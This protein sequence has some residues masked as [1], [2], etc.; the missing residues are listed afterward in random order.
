MY[1]NWIKIKYFSFIIAQVHSYDNNRLYEL[2]IVVTDWHFCHNKHSLNLVKMLFIIEF[3]INNIK[4]EFTHCYL[5]L[6]SES[7]LLHIR[8]VFL[9]HHK[10]YNEK[11]NDDQIDLP[12][13]ISFSLTS[14]FRLRND[15][16]IIIIMEQMKRRR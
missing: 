16:P 1:K 9:V 15:G 5:L 2:R 7:I 11:K 14:Y 3:I 4:I 8:I 13:L 6:N 12:F 10:L